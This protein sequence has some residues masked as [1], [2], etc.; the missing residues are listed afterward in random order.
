MTVKVLQNKQII[1]G[2]TGGIAAYKAVEVASR[3]VKAG[4][5]VDVVMTEA[6]THFVAPLTFQAITH[7]PVSLEMFALLRDVEIGHVSLAYRADLLIIAPLTANTL[8]KLAHGIADNLLT[9]VAL[10]TPA[11]ILIAPAME[12]GMWEN[13]ITQDN[14]TRLREQRD[15]TVVGPRAGR[16]ASGR[17]GMGRMAEPAEIVEAARWVLG[18][19]GPLAGRRVIVTAGGTHEPLDPIRFIGNRSSGQMGYALAA[20]ARDRGA[21]VVLIHAPTALTIPWGVEEV[22]VET[23]QEMHDAVLATLPQADALIMAAA[24]ADYRPAQVAAHKIKKVGQIGNLS[25]LELERTPDILAAV[26]ARREQLPLLQVVVGFAAET[27]DL[28]ENARRKLQSKRLDLIVANDARQAM[29]AAESQVVLLG[30]DGSVEE[31]PLLPKEQVAEEIID[32]VISL[33]SS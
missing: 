4:A 30:R 19:Q 23:A 21:E 12:T 3:L 25:Y 9:A 28:I 14:L 11:P 20:A 15:V 6:A 29:G 13:P 27:E 33:L 5:V 2:I 8:A 7:R 18:R 31:L 22:A 10:D 16:L 26:S 17:M 1:L 24:V 32:R